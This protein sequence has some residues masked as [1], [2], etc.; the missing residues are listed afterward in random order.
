[1]AYSRVPTIHAQMRS[2]LAERSREDDEF[3]RAVRA[4]LRDVSLMVSGA[5]ANM[6]DFI[7]AGVDPREVIVV[8]SFDERRYDRL[9]SLGR[10]G[11]VKLLESERMVL[12]HHALSDDESIY[13]SSEGNHR[14]RL[15]LEYGMKEIPGALIGAWY[16]P[17]P[18][19]DMIL[20]TVQ[21]I[22]VMKRHDHELQERL[23]RHPNQ[24][25]ETIWSKNGADMRYVASVPEILSGEKD[26]VADILLA[27]GANNITMPAQPF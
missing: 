19:L 6:N 5:R 17:L 25:E 20:A 26:L 24:L 7:E 1:M 27:M 11:L 8:D 12:D 21:I 23:S 2:Y 16:F 18:S 13:V 14:I 3:G 15:M 22:G 10:E 9:K 4:L